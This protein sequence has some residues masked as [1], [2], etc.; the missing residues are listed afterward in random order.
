[1]WNYRLCKQTYRS[2][3]FEE[4]AYEIREAYYNK[5][6]GIWAVTENA[7]RPFGESPGELTTVLDRMKTALDKE[8]I[9]LDTFVFARQD[10]EKDD[11]VR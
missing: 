5:D 2:E 8:I 6:G 11:I 1:M 9:D 7:A 3:S 10:I 4:V